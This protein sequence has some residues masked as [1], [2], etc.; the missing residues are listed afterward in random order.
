VEEPVQLF[1][2]DFGNDGNVQTLMSSFDRDL[3]KM[4][5]WREKSV[6]AG[7]IPSIALAAPNYHAYGRASVQE[8][9]GDKTKRV[10][11]LRA[12]SFDSMVFLNRGDHF[13]P[14]PLPIEAQ[15]APGF[16]VSVADFDGDGNEDIFLAQN[17]FGSDAEISR[18][19]AGAGLLLLGDGHG[20]FRALRPMESGISIYGEQRGSAV[21]DF[22]KDGRMDLAVAQH[23]GPTRL[24]RNVGGKAGVRITLRGTLDNPDAIGATVRLKCDGKFGPARETH[25]GGG[26]WSQDSPILVLGIPAEPTELQVRWPDGKQQTWAWPTGAKSVEVDASGIKER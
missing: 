17:F 3:S 11:E 12:A 25:A 14:R 23:N 20:G 21:A 13:E 7:A 10:H 2:G 22:D 1:Y 18:Q 26:Y 8:L 15:F 24:F 9:L 6:V 5:P 16:G 19:D 4:T